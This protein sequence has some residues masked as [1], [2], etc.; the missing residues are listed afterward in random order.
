MRTVVDSSLLR[1]AGPLPV[2]ELLKQLETQREQELNEARTIQLGMM[3]R[4]TLETAEVTVCYDFQPFYEVGG[5][6]LHFFQLGDQTIGIY[7]GDVTGKGMPALYAALAVGTL[8]GVHKKGTDPAAVLSQANRR[9]LLHNISHG[10]A[11]DCEC[12]NGRA[13]AGNVP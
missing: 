2:E 8:R 1:Q 6:F 11:E 9:M 12:R 3:P 7:L 5:D 13:A 10:S 4:G